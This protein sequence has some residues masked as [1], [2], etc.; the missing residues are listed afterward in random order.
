MCVNSIVMKLFY[1]CMFNFVLSVLLLMQHSKVGGMVGMGQSVD[2]MT[3]GKIIW[4]QKFSD[5]QSR[6]QKEQ[7]I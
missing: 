7:N 4:D 3:N 1:L 6:K 5:K 2:V